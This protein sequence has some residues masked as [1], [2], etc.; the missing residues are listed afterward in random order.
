MSNEELDGIAEE[1]LFRNY[2]RKIEYASTII[3]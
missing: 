3:H 1:T 2:K